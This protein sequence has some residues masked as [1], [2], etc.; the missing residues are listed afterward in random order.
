MSEN[1]AMI[2]LKLTEMRMLDKMD[3]A[4]IWM[5]TQYKANS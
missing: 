4:F 5:Y 1:D 3:D 2:I